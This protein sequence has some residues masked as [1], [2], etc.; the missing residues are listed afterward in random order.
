MTRIADT[1]DARARQGRRAGI[2]SRSIATAIDL[3]V[4]I[5]VGF[6]LLVMISAVVGL[7]TR[8]FDL[9]MPSQPARGILSAALL[10]AYL[11]YGWGLG[12]RTVGKVVMGLRVVGEDGADIPTWH[13]LL[14][15]LAYLVFPAGFLWALVSH[16]NASLQDMVTRTA[17]VHDW[18][19]ATT[20]DVLA[21]HA[22]RTPGGGAAGRPGS[23]DA[24]PGGQT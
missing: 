1:A 8:G 3:L 23:V 13:G 11:G 24:A 10:V 17:V 5:G 20:H 14:R 7:F 19:F 22:A 2:V 9:L 6:A 21:A 12:G 16:R 4:A 18:G 15:A